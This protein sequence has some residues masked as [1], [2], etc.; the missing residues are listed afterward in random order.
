M[1]NASSSLPR[2]FGRTRRQNP[3]RTFK[4]L[5]VSCMA[6]VAMVM[7]ASRSYGAVTITLS[8]PASV[9]SG[10]VC[11]GATNTTIYRFTLTASGTSTGNV[12]GVTFTQSG[13][14]IASDIVQYKL[15]SGSVGGTLVAT[16]TGASP[17]F[18]GFFSS[19]SGF[20]GTT[21]NY[22][23]T[24]DIAMAGAAG[25]TISVSPMGTTNFTTSATKATSGTIATGGAQTLS[26]SPTITGQAY[27][28]TGTTVTLTG[29]PSGGAWASGT[30]GVATVSAGVVG[31]VTAGTSS[32]SYTQSG[33]TAIQT[34]TVTSTPAPSFVVSPAAATICGSGS[35]TISTPPVS[36]GS[37]TVTFTSTTA[38]TVPDNSSTGAT[39]SVSVSGIPADATIVDVSVD[40]ISVTM[41]RDHDLQFNIEAPNTNILNLVDQEG[42]TFGLGGANFTNTVISSASFANFTSAPF[43]GTFGADESFNV[44]PT[45][46][47]SNVTTWSQ[48]F[49]T[50][51]G[52]WT[53]AVRDNQNSNIATVNS[54][55]VIIHYTTPPAS[56]TWG[57]TSGLYTD[58]ALTTSY[59]GVAVNTV[60]ASPTSSTVYTATRSE[61]GYCVSST[62][63]SISTSGIPSLTGLTSSQSLCF[64]SASAQTAS[65]AYTGIT[66]SASSYTLSWSPAG[67]AAV[68]TLTSL[69]GT[70]SGAISVSVPA[71]TTAGTYNGTLTV[72][73][74]GGC[75]STLPITIVVNGAPTLTGL[76]SSQNFCFIASSAQTANISYSGVTNGANMYTLTWSPGGTLTNVSSFTSLP[77]TPSGT[78]SATIPAAAAAGTYNGTVTAQNSSTGCTSTATSTVVVNGLPSLAGLS[79]AATL[80]FNGASSQT[81]SFAYTGINNGA[82]QYMLT[83]SPGG[84]ANVSS[85][86]ALPGNPSGTFSVTVPA[87]TAAGTYNGTLTLKNSTTGCS[88]T[89]AISILVNG[90]PS[91][92]GLATS[93]SLCFS[94]SSAQ[95]APFAYTSVA[96]GANQYSLTWSPSGIL[97][98]VSSF[99]ALPGGSVNTLVPAGT[100]AGT[101]NGTLTIK[102][103]TTGCTSAST[104]NTVVDGQPGLSGLVTSQSLCYN[105]SSDQAASFAFTG[106]TNGANQYMLSWSSG[107]FANVT[108]PTALPAGSFSIDVPA[109]T[110][111]GTYTGSLI[112]YN[113]ATGCNSSV[114]VT[115]VVNDLPALTGLTTSQAFCYNS[116]SDQ[117]ANYTYTG[118]TGGVDHYSLTWL[119]GG[120]LADV[121]SFTSLPAG[122]VS[123]TDPAGAAANTYNGTLT[124]QNAATGCTST[125]ALTNVIN[126]TPALTGLSTSQA[127]CFNGTSDQSASFAYTTITG[128]ADQYTLTWSPSGSLP[129]VTAF[130]ALPGGA[131]TAN[132]AAGTGVNTYTGTL[133]AE[134]STTGCSSVTTLS[135]VVNALPGITGL[136]SSQAFCFNSTT[137]QPA[138]Y[139][140]TGT[141]SGADQYMLT[142]LPSGILP[143]VAAFTALPGGSINVTVP[144]GAA[145]NSYTGN[146]TV[147][148]STTGCTSATTISNVVN[149]LPAL[150]GLAASQT[151]CFN[152]GSAQTASFAYSGVTN[153][154]DQYILT[155][156]PT[157][158]LADVNVPT[159]LPATPAGTFS[160][161]L[162]A[163]AP[164]NTYTG[165]LTVYNSSTGCNTTTSLTNIINPLPDAGT[166]TGSSTVCS[167]V[168]TSLSDASTGGTWT[169]DAPATASVNGTGSVTGG[170]AGVTTIHYAVTNSCGTAS[171][172]TL[173]TVNAIPVP[174]GITGAAAVCAGLT[175]NLGDAT[176]GGSWLTSDNTIATVN[177]SGVV[178]G[179]SGGTA[180]I[181]YGVGNVCG[182]GYATTVMTINTSPAAITGTLNVCQGS[183]TALTDVSAGGSWSSSDPG[184]ATI[185]PT[186]IVTGITA[187]G[188]P[189]IS[190]TSATGCATT[191]VVTI[192]PLPSPIAGTAVVCGGGAITTLSNLVSGGTWSSSDEGIAIASPGAPGIGIITGISFGNPTISYTLSTGCMATIIATVNPVPLP[193]TG[194]TNVCFGTAMSLSD[195]VTGGSWSSSNTAIAS[196]DPVFASVTGLSTGT[197]LITYALPTGC[198]VT[199]PVVFQ[200]IPAPITGL[201]TVCTGTTITMSDAVTGGTWSSSDATAFVDATGVVTGVA[202]GTPTISYTIATGC[203]S[204]ATIAV[205][206]PPAAPSPISGSITVCQMS[207]TLLSD[208]TPGGSW[209]SSTPAVASIDGTG[210]V[211]GF[212]A[213]ST[214]ISY[215]LTNACGS[216]SATS[217]ITVN[218]LPAMPAAIVGAS[219]VCQ[220]SS[221]IL[222]ETSFGGS[223]ST[224][225]PSVATI[226]PVGV[227]TGLS[228]GTAVI[229]YTNSNTCGLTAAMKTITVNPLP[230]SPAAIGGTASVCAAGAITTL[231]DVTTGGAWSSSN[232]L[233]AT[234]S[235]TG[236]VTGVASGISNIHYTMTN[237]C[238]SLAAIAAVTVNELPATP[239]AISGGTSAICVGTS[240]VLHD[241]VPGGVWSSSDL[242][243]AS[244]STAG[245]VNASSS[246]VAIISYTETNGCGSNT[247]IMLLT[248]NAVPAPES[249]TGAPS[250]CAGSITPLADGP[251]G[252]TWIS[253]DNSVAIVN[254]LGIVSGLT[255]G[256]ATISY[257]ATNKLRTVVYCN[258]GC[259]CKPVAISRYYQR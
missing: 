217:A 243:I 225:A 207:A 69:P 128:G 175:V 68:A 131:I 239:A 255:P 248:V 130:T 80:C 216:T 121:T 6:L 96:N 206:A 201:S 91:L 223:W 55:S 242:S 60:Y 252:G 140:Y 196:V 25:H 132:V 107:S 161:N 256:T 232:T 46:Y 244:V 15:W 97:T 166:I 85:F 246:G 53:L 158:I 245:I 1:K 63:S 104:I 221:T 222:H 202:A 147:K 44:G 182:T 76:T 124:L 150:T 173:V 203:S 86:T 116:S 118:T 72:Q 12:T 135:T 21:V 117:A 10:T 151:F 77:G 28:C 241:A 112:L 218:P 145:A 62:T 26:T 152:A 144:A 134:S 181:S 24:A 141:T 30:G 49:S 136:T 167:G 233:V 186:G 188:N 189:T 13:T 231:S 57:P 177:T 160:I 22:F 94:A 133:T 195:G 17:S 40:L 153:G 31:G 88:N 41:A 229:S 159:V 259:Y 171:T 79:S 32:I 213:G 198:Q 110:T 197:A 137:A 82:D 120:T 59:T 47:H 220:A 23:I 103:S 7:C 127:F 250:V 214:L 157:G 125:I 16:S 253:D 238:G 4:M 19:F 224:V 148:N 75:N 170:T 29:A 84:P 139:T 210:M 212:S 193:I 3:S 251:T 105:A 164:V 209:G 180:T 106:T 54:W 119:P 89:A 108:V 247:T 67:P 190:Y 156:S 38:F 122:A 42:T 254:P 226:S 143:D 71:G 56:F 39:S 98:N 123:V 5:W 146:I 200:S 192:N 205:N 73:N 129:D 95:V 172:S 211:I 2:H 102:N 87:A 111:P 81:A 90:A 101:F 165:N 115:I 114:N 113:A 163:G 66:N 155:W 179:V 9:T 78:I 154:A 37:T 187:S 50:P 174:A 208:V 149:P 100:A 257:V 169:S 183:T 204:T 258:P 58:A 33:C 36:G 142:W 52:T 240:A 43:T 64:N 14:A 18:S 235:A 51:N 219:S 27:V 109:G 35:Q 228:A 199:T 65:F 8:T 74:A 215:T 237:A 34:E 194:T 234:V 61:T 176:A 227:V 230:A 249:I 99:T 20:S 178:S 83:W 92:T 168:S 70:P 45:S 185:D 184:L 11:P 48:L 126:P 162:P 93:S 138:S 191:T 236:D